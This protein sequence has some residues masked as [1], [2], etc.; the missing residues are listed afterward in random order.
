[1]A[2]PDPKMSS[3]QNDVSFRGHYFWLQTKWE[4]GCG[5][6]SRLGLLD[7]VSRHCQPKTKKKFGNVFGRNIARWQHSTLGASP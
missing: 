5:A 1:M 3:F 4:S 6:R 2:E 7:P